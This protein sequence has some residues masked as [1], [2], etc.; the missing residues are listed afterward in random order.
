MSDGDTFRL[1]PYDAGERPAFTAVFATEQPPVDA[2]YRLPPHSDSALA[3]YVQAL[4]TAP[5]NQAATALAHADTPS[6]SISI[7]RA[8]PRHASTASTPAAAPP[9]PT[10]AVGLLDREPPPPEHD[11]PPEAPAIP[12]DPPPDAP[13][14]DEDQIVVN[15]PREGDDY[16]L[17]GK[18]H[19]VFEYYSSIGTDRVAVDANN[20]DLTDEDGNLI[21]V[22][23]K[24]VA[25]DDRTGLA[26]WIR[27][28]R[29]LIKT[30]GASSEELPDDTPELFDSNGVP[31][32]HFPVPAVGKSPVV[33]AR[34]WGTR[35][36]VFLAAVGLFAAAVAGS[37]GVY[38]GRSAV[39]ANGVISAD[40]RSTYRLTDL[41]AAA[42]AAFGQQYLQ[43]CLTHGDADQVQARA[44]ALA[45]MTTGGPSAQCGWQSGGK[46]QAPQ[47]IQWTGRFT[48]IDGFTG[49]RAAYFV[50]T[51]SMEPGRFDTYSVPIWVNT[52]AESNDM[53]IVGD[54]GVTP[55][56]RTKKPPAFTPD[57]HND[58]TL[59]SDLQSSV[60]EP[61]FTAWASSNSQQIAL[62]AS[63]DAKPDV[64]AGLNGAFSNP[65]ITS[66][67][68]YTTYD[69]TAGQ[70]VVYGNGDS[71]TAMVNVTWQVKA[72]ESTQVAG[73]RVSLR[74]NDGKWQ[75]YDIGGGALTDRAADP[76]SSSGGSSDSID[77]GISDG[78]TGGPVATSTTPQSTTAEQ[79][80]PSTDSTAETSE[81]VAP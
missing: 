4:R 77:A 58:S 14:I 54:L 10:A 68:A 65:Q 21:Y 8:R 49:G 18:G 79:P 37:C 13:A 43:T 52:A 39:P 76:N 70:R 74:Y 34:V 22:T 1:R 75:V 67:Q 2:N 36:L 51:V 44:A 63:S 61:F 47:L 19:R 3:E 9:P 28:G 25:V 38:M 32:E 24:G 81:S 64:K 80:A 60:L 27:K 40:E 12:A 48:P 62:A 11:D 20:N 35:R 29:H 45:S 66:V 71:V 5:I 69:T 7:G 26:D 50:Y 41:P 57:G 46:V 78:A 23:N 30:G 56:I 6:Q 59:A 33:T 31:I 73:Y 72:S 16:Y 42:M 53:S 17:N 55:G 15:L